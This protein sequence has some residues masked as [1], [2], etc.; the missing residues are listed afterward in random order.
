M[1]AIGLG[2]TSCGFNL[3]SSQANAM[4]ASTV[5]FN[6]G[7]NEPTTKRVASGDGRGVTR[8]MFVPSLCSD[9]K[10]FLRN[11]RDCIVNERVL[12]G[13]QPLY[14]TS[15]EKLNPGDGSILVSTEANDEGFRIVLGVKKPFQIGEV[16]MPGFVTMRMNYGLEED[17]SRPRLLELVNE[18]NGDL[19]YKF[20]VKGGSLTV[21]RTFYFE[22]AITFDYLSYH[23]QMGALQVAFMFNDAFDN[24]AMK[25]LRRDFL[26]K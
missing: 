23:I 9:D 16:T 12:C 5:A 21:E 4:T 18:L 3:S 25:E 1:V 19:F 7:P 14:L 15:I 24:P 6:A 11:L 26:N 22:D 13:T 10:E 17:I 8:K 20:Y 2:L